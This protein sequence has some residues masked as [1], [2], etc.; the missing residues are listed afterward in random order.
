MNI[1]IRFVLVTF[2]FS[3]TVST[4]AQKGTPITADNMPERLESTLLW[5]ISGNG[6]KKP[7]YLYGTIHI[8]GADDFVIH[9]NTQKYFKKTK[10]LVLEIDMSNPI[11]LSLQMMS[12]APMDSSE[13]LGN[14]LSKEDYT[15][16]EK[17]FEAK[18]GNSD[19]QLIPFSKLATW[20]PM[21][22]ESFLYQDMIKG[23]TES[24]EMTF[25]KMA[26]DREMSFGGLETVADQMHVFDEIPY[27]AQ[28]EQLVEM[29]TELEANPDS[30]T[31][32][33]A[34]LVEQYLSQDIE[35]MVEMTD[36]EYGDIDDAADLL[37]NNRNRNWIDKI[38]KYAKDQPT[39]FAVGAAHLGGESGVIRLLIKEGYTLTPIILQ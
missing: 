19:A 16:V 29:I 24:Y 38:S 31:E 28:A 4:Y 1:F 10:Q 20:K 33:F 11:M 17:Y 21:L 30:G 9:K 35:A 3:T 22:L 14:L 34:E 5:Q 26:N 8:I 15:M 2:L 23:K 37:L 39:F 6:L 12:M 25:V 7:S 36:E 32:E 18:S 27:S 13:T